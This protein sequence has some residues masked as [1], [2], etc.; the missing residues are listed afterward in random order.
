MTTSGSPAPATLAQWRA[1]C[2]RRLHR[3]RR[4]HGQPRRH[5]G[6]RHGRHLSARRSPPTNAAGTATQEF[7]LTVGNVGA[8]PL[9][10][11]GATTAF[12]VGASGGFAITTAAAPPVTAITLTGT[13]PAGITFTDNGDGTATLA[14]IADPGTGGAYP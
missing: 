14:G 11:S 8:S 7:T 10:T 2:R 4:R 6:R 12:V 13:L 9:F 1:A 3:Q 5:A